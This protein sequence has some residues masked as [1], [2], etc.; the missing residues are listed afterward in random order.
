M[1]KQNAIERPNLNK[2]TQP[3]EKEEEKNA[4]F[5]KDYAFEASNCRNGYCHQS[6]DVSI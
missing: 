1:E 4:I 6:N 3:K 2:A 5:M